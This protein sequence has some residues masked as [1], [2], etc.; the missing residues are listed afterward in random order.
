[1]C[2]LA[3]QASR[4]SHVC[5]FIL[6]FCKPSDFVF[7]LN[8]GGA[9]HSDPIISLNST[10]FGAPVIY[11]VHLVIMVSLTLVAEAN[12]TQYL[13]L[14]RGYGG[15]NVFLQNKALCKSN[16]SDLC[17]YLTL[18]PFASRDVIGAPASCLESATATTTSRASCAMSV[19]QDG[20]VPNVLR[21][22]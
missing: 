2:V 18:Q 7:I 17:Q 16:A 12:S 15:V 6:L 20:P 10:A 8:R 1:V 5:H 11:G 22:R 4:P 19:L 3:R 13:D 21:V 9:N 14:V